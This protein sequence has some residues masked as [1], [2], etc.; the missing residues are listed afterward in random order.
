MCTPIRIGFKQKGSST[1]VKTPL[2]YK[3]VALS[4]ELVGEETPLLTV[5][6]GRKLP[7]VSFESFVFSPIENG[8]SKAS[9]NS[10]FAAE[11]IP[12]ISSVS[13]GEHSPIWCFIWPLEVKILSSLV[14]VSY[15]NTAPHALPSPCAV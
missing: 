10:T 9:W 4:F 1:D 5:Y 2:L 3:W 15:V 11:Y 12:H 7:K 6:K 8:N 14:I 13:L